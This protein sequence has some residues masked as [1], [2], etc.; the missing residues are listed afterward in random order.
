MLRPSQK[1]DPGPGLSQGLSQ[2]D[3]PGPYKKLR[4]GPLSI[5]NA[6]RRI[7]FTERITDAVPYFSLE[8]ILNKLC[9]EK[10]NNHAI[11][12][13]IHANSV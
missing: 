5:T 8:D 9:H 1:V 3:E 10:K 7:F 6:N 11:R 13:S 2:N 4:L 12:L